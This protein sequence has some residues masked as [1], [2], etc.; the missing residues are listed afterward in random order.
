[1]TPLAQEP[2]KEDIHFGVSVCCCCYANGLMV[3]LVNLHWNCHGNLQACV[4]RCRVIRCLFVI[5][6]TKAAG[7]IF[8]HDFS[9][10]FASILCGQIS[11]EYI[12][13]DPCYLGVTGKLPLPMIILCV[14]FLFFALFSKFNFLFV[15]YDN[16][17]F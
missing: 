11:C 2:V 4:V 7:H 13:L 6:D 1:M 9:Y 16:K 8:Y 14:I 12:L 5:N 17:A 10:V 15:Y 3:K